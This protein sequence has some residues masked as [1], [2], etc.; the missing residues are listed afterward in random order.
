MEEELSPVPVASLVK[1]RAAGDHVPARV[2]ELC[3]YIAA[4]NLRRRR[5][6]SG[7]GD[8][9]TE[10]AGA[11]G[12]AT[13]ISSSSGS[14]WALRSKRSTAGG[15]ICDSRYGTGPY[16]GGKKSSGSSSLGVGVGRS[17]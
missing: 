14:A 6:A 3:A 15:V 16:L 9:G 2:L 1:P 8:G 10:A 11:G 17:R 7:E 13:G 5:R 12:A 4:A